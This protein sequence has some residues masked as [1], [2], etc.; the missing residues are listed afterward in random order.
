MNAFKLCRIRHRK[1]PSWP[2]WSSTTHEN[3]HTVLGVIFFK[4]DCRKLDVT[5]SWLQNDLSTEKSRV[6]SVRLL[7]GKVIKFGEFS[8]VG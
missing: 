4:T 3:Y 6:I 7:L 8:P 5:S 2:N 1:S